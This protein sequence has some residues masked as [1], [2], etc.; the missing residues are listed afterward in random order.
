MREREITTVSHSLEKIGWGILCFF[1]VG[2]GILA[3][4]INPDK[5]MFVALMI[6]IIMGILLISVNRFLIWRWKQ[7]GKVQNDSET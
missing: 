4:L 5:N 1:G 7:R 6:I 3:L 2:G